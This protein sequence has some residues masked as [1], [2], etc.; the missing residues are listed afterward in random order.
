M[1][2][3]NGL[4]G[5]L[6]IHWDLGEMAVEEDIVYSPYDYIDFNLQEYTRISV[7][8]QKAFKV[9][10]ITSSVPFK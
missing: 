7:L 1:N 3:K 4:L 8:T 9:T 2:F 10:E 5:K 6:Q